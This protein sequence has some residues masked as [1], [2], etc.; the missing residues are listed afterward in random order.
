MMTQPC[1]PNCNGNDMIHCF[2]VVGS[3]RNGWY[4]DQCGVG[5]YR[6]GTLE[7]AKQNINT[8]AQFAVRLLN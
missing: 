1:C 6:L 4:C 5:P 8:A 3:S 2:A 7:E